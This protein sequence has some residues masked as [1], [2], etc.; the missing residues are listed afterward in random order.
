MR[1]ALY[2]STARRNRPASSYQPHF[3][4]ECR[5]KAL[6]R[7]RDQH[8]AESSWCA[9]SGRRSV[10]PTVQNL[11]RFACTSCEWLKPKEPSA[12]TI[13]TITEQ[14]RVTWHKAETILTNLGYHGLRRLPTVA[15]SPPGTARRLQNEVV[16][17]RRQRVCLRNGA[18]GAASA[19]VAHHDINSTALHATR[20]TWSPSTSAQPATPGRSPRRR[21]SASPPRSVATI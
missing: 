4:Y 8:R 7:I 11:M 9:T 17:I 16:I 18:C 10:F 21:R 19:A 12:G 14:K 5:R 2:D 15:S 13:E 20:A 1:G 3:R 6:A